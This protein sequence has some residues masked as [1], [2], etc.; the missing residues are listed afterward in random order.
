MQMEGV[1]AGEVVPE[2]LEFESCVDISFGPEKGN[3]FSKKYDARE[4][5]FGS[6]PDGGEDVSHEGVEEGRVR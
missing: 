6:R 3:H 5:A 2:S 1:G 4:L